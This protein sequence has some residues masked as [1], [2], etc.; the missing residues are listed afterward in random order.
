MNSRLL[1]N[2]FYKTYKIPDC[3]K[4]NGRWLNLETNCLSLFAFSLL[5]MSFLYWFKVGATLKESF[6][7]VLCH[8]SVELCFL[9]II[10]REWKNFMNL[11]RT[12]HTLLHYRILR[13]TH[14]FTFLCRFHHKCLG[15]DS[16]EQ[17][18]KRTIE[19]EQQRS[20]R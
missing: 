2:I 1:N 8:R 11:L 7:E 16:S 4:K 6:K 15:T 10:K 20:V 17:P 9:K 18:L 13:I 5:S 3:S 14:F 12:V 19:R